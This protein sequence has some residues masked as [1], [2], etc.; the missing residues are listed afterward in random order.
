[1]MLSMQ[2]DCL[3]EWIWLLLVFVAGRFEAFNCTGRYVP[4]R[5]VAGRYVPGRFVA[6]HFVTGRFVAG[7]FVGVQYHRKPW[8]STA[9]W[10]PLA[11]LRISNRRIFANV[12]N[13][14]DFFMFRNFL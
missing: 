8:G 13:F 10:L 14:A 7:R 1:M 5:F 2:W 11:A 3:T 12:E 4:G 6:E 9:C